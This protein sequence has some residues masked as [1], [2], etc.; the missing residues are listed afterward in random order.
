M[1]GGIEVLTIIIKVVKYDTLI[2]FSWK[3]WT[4]PLMS[5]LCLISL[6]YF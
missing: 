6:K 3:N 4:E 2:L 5:E 1:E